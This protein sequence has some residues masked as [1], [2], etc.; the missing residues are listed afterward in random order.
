MAPY[1]EEFKTLV[2]EYLDA[3]IEFANLRAVTVAQWTLES[4]YGRSSLAADFR[5][6]A[7]LKWR[8]EMNG[9]ATPVDYAAHDG[10]EKYCKFATRKKFVAGYWHFL[11]R[12]PYDGW[13]DHTD[14]PEDFIRFIGPIYTPTHLYA[15]NVLALLPTAKRLI[16]D[17]GGG[18]QDFAAD[19][20][21]DALADHAGHDAFH[22]TS[23]QPP[24]P[25]VKQF[26]Q[27]PN[28]SSR[29]GMPIRRVIMH[30]TT[31]R[32]V[33]GT[34][35]HFLN[36]ASKVSAHYVIGREGAIF[37]MV[38]DGDK[39]WHAKNANADSIGIE[40]SAAQGDQMTAPQEISSV[41]LVRWLLSE[42][43]LPKSAIHGHKYT[44][45]NAGTT[46]CPE[47]LFGLDTEAALDK[48]INDKI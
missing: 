42:Y 35:S 25:S 3:D 44:P 22:G 14:T 29:N 4:G 30:Y 33:D 2:K 19:A 40:H 17:V 21:L 5:N 36:P 26:I 12:S 10:T 39:A 48:W 38:H 24:K 9:Y 20:P 16:D 15:D 13:R 46:D 8:S 28:H 18:G 27:S 45:E 41:A 11:D 34:I 37:Q 43:K 1:T 6:F 47:R 31:S 7:G 23:E 32:N